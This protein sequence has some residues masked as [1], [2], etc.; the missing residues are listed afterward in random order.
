MAAG[1][2]PCGRA[3]P[4]MA[5]CPQGVELLGMVGAGKTLGSPWFCNFNGTIFVSKLIHLKL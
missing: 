5:V 4:K 1:H 2:P 3:T